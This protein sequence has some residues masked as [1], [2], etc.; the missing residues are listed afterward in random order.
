MK[1]IIAGRDYRFTA[2]DF[3]RLDEIQGVTEVVSDAMTG[4]T[5]G[6][7][8]SQRSR[9]PHP[10]APCWKVFGLDAGPIRNE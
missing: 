5:L 2:A 7:G 6:R 1:L 3:R 4:Q 10:A 9:H 8:L